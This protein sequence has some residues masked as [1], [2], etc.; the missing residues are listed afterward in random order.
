MCL[1][2]S[3][4]RNDMRQ[5][6]ALAL[7]LLPLLPLAACSGSPA[8]GG[9]FPLEAGRQWVYEQRTEW[10]GASPESERV[11]LA[12]LGEDKLA[13]A[14]AFHRRSASGMDYWL[15]RD[16]S[17]IYRVA[18]K[19]DSQ[20]EPLPD[21]PRRYVLRQP[22]AVG[23][24]WVA[25]TTAYLLRR[26]QDFPPEIRHSARPVPMTYT[27]RAVGQPVD[28]RAGRFDDCLRVEGVAA[29]RLFA[30]P[31][32]GFRDLP[33]TTTEWYCQGVGLVKLQRDEP[34]ATAFLSGGRL[35]MELT[36]WH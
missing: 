1:R 28:T 34:A 8:G 7:P 25:T 35:T 24:Q 13:G 26:R 23:T 31:V 6:F 21:E 36:E 14:P 20:A 33:L 19:S 11:A 27:I 22:L 3:C 29:M 17:G 9:Y 2:R 5:V 4:L 18:S 10:E 16:D 12:A 30:D 15:R 32:N